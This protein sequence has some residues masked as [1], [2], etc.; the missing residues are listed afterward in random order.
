RSVDTIADSR[1]TR[2]SLSERYVAR[3]PHP[4]T[5]GKS[6]A[7]PCGMKSGVTWSGAHD[8]SC[9]PCWT[10]RIQRCASLHDEGASALIAPTGVGGGSAG[11]AVAV[12]TFSALIHW[13]T[14]LAPASH[15]VA[16]TKT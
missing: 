5:T 6:G 13:R 15:W 11:G 12:L 1:K 10:R 14:V 8:R 16:S 3:L 2:G 7:R 4:S 9:A